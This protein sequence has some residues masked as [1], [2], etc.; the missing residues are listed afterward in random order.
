MFNLHLQIILCLL[1]LYCS[2]YLKCTQL[3]LYDDHHYCALSHCS[4]YTGFWPAEYA[5]LRLPNTWASGWQ[6]PNTLASACPINKHCLSNTQAYGCPIHRP[7]SVQYTGLCLSNIQASGC[8]IHRPLTAQYTPCDCP[9][10][11][12]LPNT[13]I[14]DCPL[15]ITQLS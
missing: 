11:T 12:S 15:Y 4:I 1:K 7:L 2:N 9:I 6:L 5:G 13:H 3:C 14:S 10:Y 8:P